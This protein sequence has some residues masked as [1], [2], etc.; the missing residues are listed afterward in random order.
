MHSL[1]WWVSASMKITAFFWKNKIC[2]QHLDIMPSFSVMPVRKLQ[3][4]RWIWRDL[5]RLECRGIPSSHYN[6]SN[7]TTLTSAEQAFLCFLKRPAAVFWS[8]RDMHE[9]IY[10][11][12]AA[13]VH[14]ENRQ[15]GYGFFL[16]KLFSFPQKDWS[17]LMNMSWNNCRIQHYITRKSY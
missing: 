7:P 8:L 14:C 17:F 10:D 16:T 12:R 13:I 9:H 1:E 4:S 2:L 15:L 6:R 3:W 5:R 11:H